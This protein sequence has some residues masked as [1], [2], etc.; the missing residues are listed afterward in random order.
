MIARYNTGVMQVTGGA[1]ALS[2]VSLM[3]TAVT[4]K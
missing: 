1:G 3:D 4:G 2:M